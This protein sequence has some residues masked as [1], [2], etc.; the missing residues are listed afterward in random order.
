VSYTTDYSLAMNKA[1][2]DRNSH[3]YRCE[4]GHSSFD[5]PTAPLKRGCTKMHDM[6]DSDKDIVEYE[7]LD[8]KP[9]PQDSVAETLNDSPLQ[10]GDGP[11]PN[12]QVE[13]TATACR[14]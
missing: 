6:E 11:I 12:A 5:H 3:R 10:T 2:V 7:T 13:L 8:E 14:D 4:G 1:R 9:P